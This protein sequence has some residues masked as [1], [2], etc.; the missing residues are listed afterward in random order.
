M[1]EANDDGHAPPVD[2]AFRRA[3][4]LILLGTVVVCVS[5]LPIHPLAFVAFIV[6]GAAL[7]V[8]GMVLL[9]WSGVAN[10]TATR[11]D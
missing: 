1:K 5:L 8:L 10:W 11:T 4:W 9:I 2:V 7:M 3:A 6:P